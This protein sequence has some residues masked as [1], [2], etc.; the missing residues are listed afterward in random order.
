VNTKEAIKNLEMMS[1][2][3]GKEANKPRNYN[4]EF[5]YYLEM[6]SFEMHKMANE[7]RELSLKI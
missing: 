2:E 4:T 7:L 3:L 5:S 6:M 1:L